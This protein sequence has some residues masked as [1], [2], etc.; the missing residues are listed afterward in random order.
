MI[1]QRSSNIADNIPP[2]SEI[3]NYK[4]GR[5]LYPAS[6][7]SAVTI[8]NTPAFEFLKGDFVSRFP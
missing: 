3:G 8:G 2:K 6:L 1:V 7:L 5:L 4:R